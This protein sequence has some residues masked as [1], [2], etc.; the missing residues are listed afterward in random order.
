[1]LPNFGS[2]VVS[3]VGSAL[4][5]LDSLQN[6]AMA[7]STS[8]TGTYTVYSTFIFARTG[9]RTPTLQQGGETIQLTAY[10]ANQMYSM[11]RPHTESYERSRSIVNIGKGIVLSRS[12]HWNRHRGSSYDSR[13]F[14]NTDK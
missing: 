14:A 1:M 6:G 10:G 9:E 13:T 5:L 12:I 2:R 4:V 11:V 8:P 7:Q 3:V